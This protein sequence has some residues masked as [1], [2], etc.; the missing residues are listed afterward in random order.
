VAGYAALRQRGKQAIRT[1]DARKFFCSGQP[2]ET[3]IKSSVRPELVEG[4]A[5]PIDCYRFNPIMV[6]Q[7]HHE[8]I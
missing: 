8:R 3:Q 7:A 1:A 4:L 6:R 2:K 5:V